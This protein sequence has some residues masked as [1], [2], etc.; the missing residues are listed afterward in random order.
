M[1]KFVTRV[2]QRLMGATAASRSEAVTWTVHALGEFLDAESIVIRRNDHAR[3][4]SVLESAWPRGRP[5]SPLTDSEVAFEADPFIGAASALTAAAV[6]DPAGPPDGYLAL[7]AP[8]P[9]AAGTVAAFPL[10][11]GDVT[12]GFLVVRLSENGRR[13]ATQ[14]LEGLEAIAGLLAQFDVRIK[15]ESLSIHLAMHDELTGMPNRRALIQ[16]LG[17][18]L[19]GGMPT[20]LLLADLDRFKVMN[21]YLG[22]QAGD[23]VLAVIAER[24]CHSIGPGDFAARL[25]SDEFVVVPSIAGNDA[26]S[27]ARAH[28]LL[29]VIAQPIYIGGQEVIHTASVGIAG[30]PDGDATASDLLGWADIALHGAKAAG[31]NRA[32]VLDD[33]LRAAVDERS[34]TELTLRRAIERNGLRLHYQPELDM[35]T[36][37]LLAVE[38]LVRWRHSSRGLITAAEFIP[39]AEET[40]LVVELGRWVLIE[41]CEQVSKWIR[42]YPQTPIVVRFNMSPV[43]FMSRGIVEF[44]DECLQH[45][46]VPGDHLCVEIT[47]R[48]AMR[49][50]DPT[51]PL[52][53]RLRDLGLAIALDDFGTGYASM[54]DLKRLPVTALKLDQGFV[55]NVAT[56]RSDQAIVEAIIRLGMALGLDVVAEGIESPSTVDKLLELGCFRGQ[57]FLFSMPLSA[58]A[59]APVLERGRLDL[60]HSLPPCAPGDNGAAHGMSP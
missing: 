1:L 9:D 21:D 13:F 33:D 19:A 58:K 51:I 4:R 25:G 54:T 17:Q 31:K 37:E 3:G 47:E 36:G 46:G 38:A 57:G 23:R 14:E 2:A 28:R 26:E 59:L 35:R 11:S 52:L 5:A 49:D 18:R 27:L 22:H 60:D 15:A 34:S 55:K 16:M 12:R 8:D 20:T 6:H 45:Y 29:E 48:A 24:I 43:Q 44:I 40:G 7:P 30:S 50:A 53:R 39:V 10:S 41:T 32:L 56:D 42:D